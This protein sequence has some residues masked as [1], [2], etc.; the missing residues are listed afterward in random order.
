MS[1]L[2]HSQTRQQSPCVTTVKWWSSRDSSV[3]IATGAGG[4]L[5][6]PGKGKIFFS[7][8]KRSDRFWDPPSLPCRK[9]QASLFPRVTRLADRLTT[10]LRIRRAIPASPT[11]SHGTKFTFHQQLACQFTYVTTRLL[12]SVCVCVSSQ[13]NYTFIHSIRDQPFCST[14]SDYIGQQSKC[15]F[16]PQGI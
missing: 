4:S 10:Q 8:L 12:W 11:R 5:S 6:S 13:H 3:G 1:S 14:S 9:H 7:S 2:S 16:L 15:C